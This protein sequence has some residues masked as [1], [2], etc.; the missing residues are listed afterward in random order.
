[1]EGTAS[2]V[3]RRDGAILAVRLARFLRE[4]FPPAAYLPLIAVFTAAGFIPA[5]QWQG[6]EPAAIPFVFAALAVT[7]VFL[8]LRV[9][10]ELKDA[11][12]DRLGRPERPLPRGLVGAD[13][14][15]WMAVATLGAAV[16][17][18]LP[19][20]VPAVAG[21]LL[22]VAFVALADV[23]F[24]VRRIL[25]R[26]LIVYALVHS[27]SVPLLLVFSWLAG[28]AAPAVPMA[29]LVLLGWSAGLGFEVARKSRPPEE[30]RR[31][32][33]TYSAAF[34]Y[35]PALNLAGAA[36]ALSALAGAGFAWSIAGG[37]TWP[38]ALAAL[39][40]LVMPVTWY[41]VARRLRQRQTEAVASLIVL[42]LLA[43]PTV[44]SLAL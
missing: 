25:H 31:N 27:P 16:L 14:L 12:I 1:M 24:G 44:S 41:A 20:G 5:G 32:V 28:G 3:S 38:A 29:W 35:A 18:T 17:L 40:A 43:W 23:D 6:R 8:H 26:N 39:A 33:E 22:V 21:M 37:G 36:L 2:G 34:G 42:I 13:E 10:D 9:V 19:L 15:A 7:A 30:E 4:R 11:A